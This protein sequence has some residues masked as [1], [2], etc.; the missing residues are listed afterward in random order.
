[1][2][3]FFLLL[4][5]FVSVGFSQDV[6]RDIQMIRQEYGN[7]ESSFN[8]F[9]K[10][11]V[12]IM[13]Q[14]TEGGEATAYIKSNRIKKVNTILLGETGKDVFVFYYKDD[15]L[16]FVLSTRHHYNVPIYWDAKTAEE[17]EV[18]EVFDESKTKIEENRYYFKDN[19]IIKWLG[20]DE[21]PIRTTPEVYEKEAQILVELSNELKQEITEY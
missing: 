19:E 20:N 1:M 15:S 21:K 9:E 2:K 4:F 18:D 11:T 8:N 14:S 17:Y 13:N 7:I 12:S 6:E 3:F 5:L 10:K 16:F